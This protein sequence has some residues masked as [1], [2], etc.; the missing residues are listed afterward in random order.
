M[1]DGPFRH[2]LAFWKPLA[3][4][5][6]LE[7]MARYG[8]PGD[9]RRGCVNSWRA[10]G[11]P[12]QYRVTHDGVR[13]SLF[14]VVHPI[15][16]VPDGAAPLAEIT[17]L[18]GK[19]H[20]FVLWFAEERCAVIPFDPSA[21]VEAL[22]FEHYVPEARRTVLPMPVLAAY[23]SVKPLI[24]ASLRRQLR[25]LV[26]RNAEQAEPFLSWPSDQSLD[27]LMNLQLRLML[28]V[29]DR[30]NMPFVWFWPDGHPWAAI[31]THDVETAAGLANVAHV[32]QVEEQRH[33][34][35]SFNFVPYDYEVPGSVLSELRDSGFEIGVH[36]YK[37]DGLM[38]SAWPIFLERVVAVNEYGRRWGA[39][40]FRSPA[41]YRNPEW[42]HLLGFEYDSSMTDTAPFEPQ[43]GGCG[44]LFPYLADGLIELPMTLPQDHTLFCLL[45][46]TDS[47]V[48]LAKLAR[49]RDA[50]GMACVLTH[51]DPGEGYVGRAENE[52]RYGE[53]LD[54][55]ADS[56]AWTPLPCELSRWWRERSVIEPGSDEM[57][58]RA[59]LG[60]AM[61][62]ERGALRVVAPTP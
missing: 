9:R 44:S 39:A 58:N 61:L 18:Y 3:D 28:M 41:T 59:T 12:Q 57:P 46:H 60:H 14:A 2:A 32:A 48:W 1:T 26:A 56:D 42:F 10:D 54:F 16:V 30:E 4:G 51:P 38:F 37:H 13:F 11:D 52:V 5:D 36:G 47:A 43:P 19:H 24:P 34:A 49:I 15:D 53:V 23:Y 17:D 31:L 27:Q 22:W 62:D 7:V 20:S 45:G 25:R 8:S 50:C 35:S 40:G 33:L 55:I 29:L 6:E 21:A